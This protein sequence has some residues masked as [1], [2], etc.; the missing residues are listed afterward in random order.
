MF[1][2]LLA[3]LAFLALPTPAMAVTTYTGTVLQN[4]NG[5]PSS[6]SGDP[7]GIFGGLYLHNK[8]FSL[9]MDGKSFISLT[10]ASVTTTRAPTS[11]T[12]PPAGY[13]FDGSF[14]YREERPVY[15][16]TS[17]APPPCPHP[18]DGWMLNPVFTSGWLQIASVTTVPVPGAML[19]LAT[20]LVGLLGWRRLSNS[21]NLHDQGA[22]AS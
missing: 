18:V 13:T 12:L 2:R 19:L 7:V 8:P 22:L 14:F 15:C 6:W 9:V 3:A 20:A 17:P 21:R 5:G 10:I 16:G 4:P 11:L 1:S